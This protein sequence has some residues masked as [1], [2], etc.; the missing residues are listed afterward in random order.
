[1][2]KN[3]VVFICLV[4]SLTVLN[5]YSQENLWLK[6]T[7]SG[8]Y[9]GEKSKLTK[10]FDTR[11]QIT[12]V[13]GSSFE[14]IVQCILP[15]DTT[16]RLHTRITGRIYPRHIMTKLKQVT[17]FKDPPGRY[18][19]AKHCNLCDSMKYTFEKVGDSIVIQGERRC[20]TLCNI[21]ARYTKSIGSLVYKAAFLYDPDIT[22]RRLNAKTV[23]TG[24]NKPG[25]VTTNS[26][27]VAANVTAGASTP[28]KPA[29]GAPASGAVADT[30]RPVA[31]NVAASGSANNPAAGN[32]VGAA[33]AATPT[34]G[35]A[36]DENGTNAAPAKTGGANTATAKT[37]SAGVDF[38][39]PV[40]KD[41]LVGRDHFAGR[42]VAM[43]TRYVI[44]ADSAEIRFMDNG[45][46]DGDTISV[47]YNGQLIVPKLSLKEKPYIIKVPLF[48]DYPNRLVIHA[49]SLGIYPP[50]TAL[51]RII[52]GKKEESFLLSSSMSK[53]GSVELMN[54]KGS[55]VSRLPGQ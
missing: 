29:A 34:T 52:T 17:Y 16:I 49:E 25:A 3:V 30:D 28:N 33:M 53:S 42:A 39:K 37:G 14:G 6:G 15:S 10:T 11:L 36:G 43:P 22:P 55:T 27:P 1:M 23:E 21:V 26:K 54:N 12:K 44:N 48:P 5:G 40:Y 9:F 13:N 19:W 46:V 50:N 38:V 35:A 41:S 4:C 45:I 7:W 18:T 31:G 20:D 47:Y 32:P 8:V 51:V 2:T 24:A